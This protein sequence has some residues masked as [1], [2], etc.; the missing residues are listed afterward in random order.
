MLCRLTR[1]VDFV[2]VLAMP[3]CIRSAHFAVHH[4]AARPQAPLRRS[5]KVV[6]TELSTAGDQA[7][8]QPVDD[9]PE[10]TWIGTVVPKRHA[11]RS[12]TRSLLKR[13]IHEVLSRLGAALP[14]GLYVVRL[15]APFDRQRFRSAAS[16]ALREAAG[17]ELGGLLPRLVLPPVQR[18]RR[19]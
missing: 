15:K 13:Q 9:L 5:V 10:Q 8:P 16:A 6:S 1:S 2:R 19:G 11:R 3:A 14:A 17:A 18:A 4:V 12:V 7:F